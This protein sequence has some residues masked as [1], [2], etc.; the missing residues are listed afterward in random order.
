MKQIQ[1]G[2]TGR[3]V[4]YREG[5]VLIFSAGTD[6]AWSPLL[7]ED[8][9]LFQLVLRKSPT[10]TIEHKPSFDDL[11]AGEKITNYLAD[12]SRLPLCSSGSS[13]SRE[14]KLGT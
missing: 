4:T 13:T 6:D 10:R 11:C 7:E 14:L 12:D 2:L 1:L 8:D 5:V 3:N 9:L